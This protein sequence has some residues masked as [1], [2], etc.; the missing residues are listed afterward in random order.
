MLSELSFLYKFVRSM[1]T[2]LASSVTFPPTSSSCLD[3]KAFSNCSFA[4][5]IVI[6]KMSL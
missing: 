6:D 3:K 4:S 2:R 5:L 1:P